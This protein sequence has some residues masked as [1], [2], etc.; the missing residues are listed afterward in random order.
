MLLEQLS[1][2]FGVS[3]VEDDVRKIIVAAAKPYADEWHIDTMGNVFFTRKCRVRTSPKPLRVMV[4]AHMDEVGVIITKITD[5]GHL[6]FK[7]VGNINQRVLPGKGREPFHVEHRKWD[8]SFARR[9]GEESKA[10][11]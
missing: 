9:S 1:N 11:R 7:P 3:S 8:R 4:T 10:S 2:A 5:Q 6:K